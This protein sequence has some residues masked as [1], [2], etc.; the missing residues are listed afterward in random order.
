MGVVLLLD[1]GKGLILFDPE[2]GGGWVV[3]IFFHILLANIFNKC[4]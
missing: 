3:D 2:V 1:H 4:H